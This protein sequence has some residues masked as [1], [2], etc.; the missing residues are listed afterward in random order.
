MVRPRSLAT[1]LTL[2]RRLPSGQRNIGGSRVIVINH[3]ILLYLV[4]RQRVAAQNLDRRMSHTIIF[5]FVA[6]GTPQTYTAAGENSAPLLT[7]IE[8]I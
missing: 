6:S 4:G 8:K 1:Q 3:I 5:E 7:T 2:Q